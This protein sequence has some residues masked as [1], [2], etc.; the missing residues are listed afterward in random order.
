MNE[1]KSIH[2][3]DARRAKMPNLFLIGASKSGSSALHAYLGQHPDIAASSEKEPCFFVDQAEL[4]EAWPIRSRHAHSYDLD[5]YLALWPSDTT[6]RYRVEASV[7]YSQT[8]HR[9]RVP[10]RIF[11][12]CPQARI[13][14]VVR[15]P[16]E[17]A[18]G[19]YWQRFKE[20]QETRSLDDALREEPLYRD[21]SDYALQL[22]AYLKVFP[23]EQIRIVIAEELRAARRDTLQSLFDWLGIA[24]VTLS[25]TQ[26]RDRHVSPSTS[27]AA[28]HPAIRAVRD[29][30][31]WAQMRR[32]LPRSAVDYLRRQATRP[33][34]K[35]A[36]DDAAARAWLA[37]E[38][39]PRRAAFE[40]L[41][42]R[43][44]DAWD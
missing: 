40:A 13:I 20:F 21:T 36:V 16:A 6:A 43:H 32:V 19:H 27:R 41:L 38:L 14:Y 42:G 15:E 34:D 37:S 4:Q 23:R 12:A 11:S 10:E 28:R 25:D 30:A 7:Y 3:S 26:L 8:P 1:T 24:S 17:R 9:S 39:A 18:I 44:V 35:T 33:V 31:L 2:A 5:A 29:S 22:E